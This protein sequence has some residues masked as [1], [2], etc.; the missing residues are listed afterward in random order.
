MDADLYE[1]LNSTITQPPPSPSPSSPS[2]GLGEE[3]GEDG[4]LG[5][6][7]GEDGDGREK[8]RTRRRTSSVSLPQEIDQVVNAIVASPWAA[9]LGALVGNVRKQV[10]IPE[11]TM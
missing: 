6:E 1:H 5:D 9:R 11:R 10:C 2:P 3:R 4:E 7:V 8:R